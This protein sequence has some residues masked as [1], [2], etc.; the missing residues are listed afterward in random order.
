MNSR[1][2]ATQYRMA[3]WALIIQDC[4]ASGESVK[5]YCQSR[6]LSRDS[7]FSW[8]RKLR[9]ATCEQLVAFQSET[10]PQ[11]LIPSGFTEVKL[12][13]NHEPSPKSQRQTALNESLH[14]EI[15]SVKLRAGASYPAEKLAYLLKELVK[16]C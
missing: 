7:Y 1:E 13:P 12:R 2:V 9:E 5:E 3:K 8:Q 14:I 16:P 10:A 4:K 6:G 15:S 11:G